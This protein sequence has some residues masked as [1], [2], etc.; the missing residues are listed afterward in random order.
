[1]QDHDKFD[2]TRINVLIVD[3]NAQSLDIMAQVLTGF[4]ARNLTRC[5]SAKEARDALAIHRFDLILSDASMP[6]EDG[7]DLLKWL[8]REGKEPNRFCPALIVTGHTRSSQVKKARDCG[9]H[10]VVAKPIQPNI[11]LER[12]FWVARD[13]R[14]F[15]DCEAYA[16][17]D[18]RF[19]FE[20]PPPG[21]EGRR[22]NDLPAEVGAATEGNMSQDELD[23]MMKVAKVAL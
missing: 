20:G 21:E 5:S 17:P 16:G 4:G 22:G 10:F 18:R 8:R 12:I 13:E 19:K 23:A 9:A 11:L 2:L 14:M 15:V 6:G 7:Y 1:M 3:D